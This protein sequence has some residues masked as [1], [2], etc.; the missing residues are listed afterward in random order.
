MGEEM[1]GSR[2]VPLE[3]HLETGPFSFAQHLYLLLPVL[4]ALQQAAVS[5]CD[6]HLPYHRTTEPT[7][8][9]SRLLKPNPKQVLPL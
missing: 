8:H 7:G 1:A 4:A 5:Y 3:G 6:G 2:W 9:C